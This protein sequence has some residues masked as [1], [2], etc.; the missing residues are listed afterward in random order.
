VGDAGSVSPGKAIFPVKILSL[1]KNTVSQVQMDLGALGA[2]TELPYELRRYFSEPAGAVALP[3]YL[4]IL[5][6][7][8]PDGIANAA[9]LMLAAYEG[10]HARRAP[11]SVC[12]RGSD[13]FLVKDG[14][15][16]VLNAVAS[17]WPDILC[18]VRPPSI[19][20]R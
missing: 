3:L 15:S 9:R 1:D 19:F 6:R 12:P 13:G 17:A 20:A 14:N 11:V 18:V 5:S 7:A 16:T 10:R 4:L 2:S 8:R